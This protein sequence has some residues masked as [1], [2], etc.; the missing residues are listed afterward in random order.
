MAFVEHRRYP[1]EF[2]F[3]A[4]YIVSDFTFL[5]HWHTE[6]ELLYVLEGHLTIGINQVTYELHAGDIA[7]IGSGDIHYYSG[8][9]EKA[10]AIMVIFHPK[11]IGYERGW[12]IHN[13]FI[14]PVMTASSFQADEQESI[15]Q[16]FLHAIEEFEHRGSGWEMF[17]VSE[18]NKICA[19]LTRISDQKGSLQEAW[20]KLALRNTEIMQ[21]AL[22][23]IEEKYN[24]DINLEDT[25]KILNVSPFYFSRLF[26]KTV[27]M[28]FRSYINHLRMNRAYSMIVNTDQSLS[29][30]AMECGFQ[31]IRSFNRVFK[32]VKGIS[33]SSFRQHNS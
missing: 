26:N 30:I 32:S 6:V 22:H 20:N 27:G 33:P 18:V 14:S 28:N 17:A 4:H 31:S 25:A 1:S 15:K 2:Q 21:N 3:A 13:Q 5:A 10:R 12:K 9:S 23:Y 19:M 8:S 7:V 29:T 24:E 16:A 11:M